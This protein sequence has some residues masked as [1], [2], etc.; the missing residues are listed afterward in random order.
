MISLIFSSN[1]SLKFDIVVG[2]LI[3][4]GEPTVSHPAAAIP[5]SAHNSKDYKQDGESLGG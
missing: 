3:Y 1:F 4:C 2:V 5:I